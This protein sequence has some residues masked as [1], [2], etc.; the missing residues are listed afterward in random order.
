MPTCE[1]CGKRA[2]FLNDAIVEG[3]M[4]SVCDDCSG[5][6][7]VIK[8]S[9]PKEV[10]EQV[11]PRKIISAETVKRVESIIPNYAEL[12]KNA[13]EKLKL[14]QEEV[15]KRLAEKESVIHNVETGHLEPSIKLAKKF[16]QFF[17]IKLIEEIKETSEEPLNL[18][19]SQL[20][21]RD[22]IKIKE[23]IEDDD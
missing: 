6:G 1:M 8:L 15:A 14:K 4:L 10:E 23:D 20:T 18:N 17:R 12:V 9:R 22:L 19:N 16:E 7:K 5:F 11:M 2:E 21:I 3:A 13:R